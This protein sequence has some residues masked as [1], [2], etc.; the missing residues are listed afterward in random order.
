MSTPSGGAASG[1]VGNGG[2]SNDENNGNNSENN[3][4]GSTPVITDGTIISVIAT[5]ETDAEKILLLLSL[6]AANSLVL[7]EM[8]N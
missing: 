2:G 6:G 3:N 1:N 8:S 7:E 5:V 4:G